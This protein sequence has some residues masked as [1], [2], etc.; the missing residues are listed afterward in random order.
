[1]GL[2]G[3]NGA[4]KTDACFNMLTGVYQPQTG[5]DHARRPGGS[6]GAQPYQIRRGGTVAHVS[7]PSACFGELSRAGQRAPRGAHLRGRHSLHD[8]LL[9]I[10]F[11]NRRQEQLAIERQPR[12]SCS[13]CFDLCAREDEQAKNL[14]YGDHATSR[15]SCARWRRNRKIHPARRTRRRMNPASSKDALGRRDPPHPAPTFGL[16]VL[17]IEHDM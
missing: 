16:T 1:M 8:T 13:A 14:C 7:E 3:P 9:P 10:A 17:L 4:G 5:A 11:S 2:I 6:M 15:R 12:V